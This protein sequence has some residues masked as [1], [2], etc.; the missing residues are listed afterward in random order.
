[1]S[2][3]TEKMAVEWFANKIDYIIPFVSDEHAKY[4]NSLIEQA[5]EME[6]RQ[7]V[8]AWSNG[9]DEDDRSTSNP[10]KYYNEIY[11]GNK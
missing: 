5:K 3:E 8:D 6:K 11:G 10:F 9:F 2:N 4:F 1:M 7:I